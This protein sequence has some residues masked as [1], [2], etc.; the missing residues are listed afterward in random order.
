MS[1]NFAIMGLPGLSGSSGSGGYSNPINPSAGGYPV[2]GLVAPAAPIQL[3]PIAPPSPAK[4][5]TRVQTIQPAGLGTYLLD[6][7]GSVPSAIGGTIENYWQDVKGAATKVAVSTG[8][9]IATIGGDISSGVSAAAT[10][11][12]N[13]ATSIETGAANAVKGAENTV[14]GFATG[15]QADIQ[16]A[17]STVPY[18]F[19]LALI[20]LLIFGWIE[21][22]RPGAAK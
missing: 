14:T 10:G 2:T 20:G 9:G 22:G 21:L 12:K 1:T 15:V 19:G 16:G 3:P 7:A 4:A 6:F 11:V 17:F 8:S 5:Q 13:V 18:I